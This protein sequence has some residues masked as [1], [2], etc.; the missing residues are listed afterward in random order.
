MATEDRLGIER[1][2]I[3]SVSNGAGQDRLCDV[4]HRQAQ[5]YPL[6]PAC[7]LLD[8]QGQEIMKMTYSELDR[9]ARAVAALLQR[10]AE[11][12]ETALLALPSGVDFFVALYACAYAGIVGVPVPSPG[13]G[14]SS[15]KARLTGVIEDAMASLV[16]TTPEVADQAD[17]YGLTGTDVIAVARV[18][19]ELADKFQD[20]GQPPETIA[21][22][23]Y[24]S[25]STSEPKGVQISHRNA[26]VNLHD[27]IE[28]IPISLA[29][30]D[31]L[32]V[33]SWLPLFHD[34]GLLQALLPVV[35]G[36]F[37]V[38]IS[39]ASFLFRPVVWL[40]AM[41]RY[42]A[43]VSTS[44]NFG[45][46]LCAR[47]VT[48]E[49][50]GNLDLSAWRV[51]VNGSEPIHAQTLDLFARTFRGAGFDSAAFACGYGLAE[52]TFFVSCSLNNAEPVTVS[53]PALER[54]SIVRPPAGNEPA[55]AVVSCGKMGAALDVRIVHSDALRECTAGQVGEIWIA[56]E[57]VSRGYWR[58][59]DE[60]FG[61][62]L[63]SAPGRQFFR[64]GDLGFCHSDEL[65]VLGRLDDVIILD[66]RNHYPQDIELTV[67]ESHNALAH[68]RVAAFGYSRDD[69]T[70][71]AVVA[72][73]AKGIR[74]AASG[75]TPGSGQL[76]GTEVVRA[77]RSAVSAEHQ[78]RVA[79][80]VLLRPS[81]LPRTT[82]G[83][84]R[85]RRCRE[86][87]LTG[88]LKRW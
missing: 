26:L 57:N 41:T 78:I 86:L 37:I 85:R 25:G 23:Q 71:V 68:G 50:M 52:S 82:S 40:E 31:R 45:Y 44:P 88:T 74:I 83:K 22:L 51:A 33:V 10:R 1:S 5:R 48:V 3:D 61:A 8:R 53:V 79:Q 69:A 87:F 54:E 55:R 43:Q 15:G 73:T 32:R 77:V 49:Q 28:T 67:Q 30:G 20:L 42:R 36:G 9:R 65:Y 59:A 76:D 4:L 34:M 38:L 11:P 6:Q 80:V 60:R 56:G 35:S 46:D 84:V 64:T 39:S 14:A 2:R 12:G 75:L 29:D 24:T 16:L 13:E 81:G 7:I 58:R 27:F 66:G 17:Q 47:R 21:W 62:T 70:E 18:R 19:P 72:E 63:A